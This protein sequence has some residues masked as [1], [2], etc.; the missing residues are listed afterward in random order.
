MCS[1]CPRCARAVHTRPRRGEDTW[2]ESLK[3]FCQMEHDATTML[4]LA[5]SVLYTR[6]T[7]APVP[8]QA[9]GYSEGGDAYCYITYERGGVILDSSEQWSAFNRRPKRSLQ[10]TLHAFLCLCVRW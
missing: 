9:V 5:M 7:G 4:S 3:N 2:Q 6:C 10:S 1:L 8:R